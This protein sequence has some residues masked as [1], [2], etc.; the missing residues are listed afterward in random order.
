MSETLAK[1]PGFARVSRRA[2]A[3]AGTVLLG[4]GPVAVLASNGTVALLAAIALGA[5]LVDLGRAARL[6]A[7][8]GGIACAAFLAWCLAS[9]LW[10]ESAFEAAEAGARL[11]LLVAVAFVAVAVARGL[12]LE[13]RAF[14]ARCLLA[15]LAVMIVLFVVEIATGSGV[16]ELIR[17]APLNALT[18]TSRGSVVLAIVLWPGIGLLGLWLKRPAFAVALWV[19]SALVILN[20]NMSASKIALAGATA[21][22]ALAWVRPRVAVRSIQVMVVAAMLLFPLVPRYAMNQAT[23]G[24][25]GQQRLAS[26]WQHRVQIWQFTEGQIAMRPLLGHGFDASR[27]IAGQDQPLYL[28]TPAGDAYRIGKLFSLHPHNAYLQ[29]WLELGAIGAL[30]A[31]TMAAWLI[32]LVLRLSDDRRVQALAAAAV[33]SFLVNASVSFGIWQ[34]WFLATAALGAVALVLV[35]GLARKN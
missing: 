13:G 29:V 20:L 11:A 8:P 21:M 25:E 33:T 7:S 16:R 10:A 2:R 3:L 9:A 24:M 5:R 14:A 31:A 6:A 35:A 32:G 18:K 12:D 34:S 28:L 17:G 1:P 4:L 22:F 15:G 19:A 27:T 30:L 23:L 26:S